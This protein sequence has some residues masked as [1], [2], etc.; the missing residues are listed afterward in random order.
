[1][2]LHT[3]I[4]YIHLTVPSLSTS[5]AAVVDPM[6]IHCRLGHPSLDKLKTMVPSL[7]KVSSLE[8]ETC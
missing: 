8:C 5:Y 3:Y 2:P 4:Q 6:S 7:S 1:M